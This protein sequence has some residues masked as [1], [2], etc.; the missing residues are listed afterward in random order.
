MRKLIGLLV[1]LLAAVGAV[2]TILFFWRKKQGSWSAM[3]SSAKDTTTSWGKTAANE[4]GKAADKITAGS[5]D[6]TKAA[7]NLA[8]ELKGAV[9]SSQ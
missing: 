5:D 1:G 2:V 3:C 6:T 9:G 7:S 4:A 8:D